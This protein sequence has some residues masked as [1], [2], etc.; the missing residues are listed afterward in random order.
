MPQNITEQSA[1]LSCGVALAA[2]FEHSTQLSVLVPLP[3]PRHHDP[4]GDAIRIL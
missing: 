3:I 2:F 1:L 4:G